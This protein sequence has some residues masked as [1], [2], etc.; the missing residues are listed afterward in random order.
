M[1]KYNLGEV[2]GITVTELWSGTTGSN[3]GSTSGTITFEKDLS[4]YKLLVLD[5]TV[6]FNNSKRYFSQIVSVQHVIDFVNNN[7]TSVKSFGFCWGYSG[8]SDFFNILNTST[9]KSWDY[10]TSNSQCVRILGIN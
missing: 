1:D 5:F 10:S 8:S 2:G 7:S 9:L 3:T 4:N 6:G